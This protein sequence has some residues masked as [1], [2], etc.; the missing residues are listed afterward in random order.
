MSKTKLFD[1][2][3]Y[4]YG[5]FIYT[6][7]FSGILFYFYYQALSF[8]YPQL[9]YPESY[10][11]SAFGLRS[12]T[13]N[14][15]LNTI[16]FTSPLLALFSDKLENKTTRFPR[17]S[18][19][20]LVGCI[21]FLITSILLIF[22]ITTALSFAIL[23]LLS[24]IF[25]TI[26]K[27]AIQG[28]IIDTSSGHPKIENK[29]IITQIGVHFGTLIGYIIS[30]QIVFNPYFSFTIQDMILAFFLIIV[31]FSPLVILSILLLFDSTGKKLRNSMLKKEKYARLID[32]L[33]GTK[34][35]ITKRTVQHFQL[36]EISLRKSYKYI[37]IFLVLFSLT[38]IADSSLYFWMT[39]NDKYITI[40]FE[41]AKLLTYLINTMSIIGAIIT[42]ILLKYLSRRKILT[43]LIPII[44]F[45]YM[46]I[47]LTNSIVWSI[48]G[49]F[50]QL[51]Q[52]IIL[53][54]IMS[55]AAEFA[56]DGKSY[57][58][59]IIM[60]VQSIVSFIITT[61]FSWFIYNP[62]SEA[63]FIVF[64]II[65]I[66]V[67]LSLIPIRYMKGE[68]KIEQ[69]CEKCQNKSFENANFCVYCGF[70]K[71]DTLFEIRQSVK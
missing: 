48:W 11:L 3:L 29:F 63:F 14:F 70:K 9:P 31:L 40:D 41:I 49:F 35:K 51:V 42:F 47:P 26:T 57:K 2:T 15:I 37:I 8:G 19:S 21:G 67:L 64:L 53:I 65:G 59:Q 32:R 62:S 60:A 5:N 66:L 61:Y 45:S 28:R 22:S 20:L 16:I 52:S 34:S 55:M 36:E 18:L 71:E 23:W 10:Y 54:V 1:N 12:L 68:L 69:Y 25:L 30:Y 13:Q 33:S 58:F 44:A 7:I 17:R 6:L 43:F 27:A 4:F 24:F 46:C 56:R 50:V 39:Y 38:I